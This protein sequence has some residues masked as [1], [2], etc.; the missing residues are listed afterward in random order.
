MNSRQVDVKNHDQEP[1]VIKKKAMYAGKDPSR[2]ID[3][4]H[5]YFGV[6][7]FSLSWPLM[8]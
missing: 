3:S 6:G 5:T 1:H 4:D 2:L 8:T 7:V